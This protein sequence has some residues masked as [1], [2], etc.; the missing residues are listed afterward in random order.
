MHSHILLPKHLNVTRLAKQSSDISGQVQIAA[1]PHAAGL[2]HLEADSEELAAVRFNFDI[3]RRGL[4]VVSGEI[5]AKLALTC[6]RCL[7]IVNYF[8]HSTFQL[9]PVAVNK[10]TELPEGYE[11]ILLDDGI[12]D[13]YAV[14]EEEIMLSIPQIAMHED[15]VCSNQEA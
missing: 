8:C 10:S 7:G 9:S 13:V 3:D 12:M 11:P 4:V 14:L 6:Q 2:L 1:L 5:K 15:L